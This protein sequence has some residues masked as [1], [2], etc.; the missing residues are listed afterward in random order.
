MPWEE[1]IILSNKR[2]AQIVFTRWIVHNIG[3]GGRFMY[4]FDFQSIDGG[5]RYAV[6]PESYAGSQTA[7]GDSGF[8]EMLWFEYPQPVSFVAQAPDGR[9]TKDEE[10]DV[11]AILSSFCVD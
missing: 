4:Q 9:F 7:V 5:E 10:K 3:G 11:I 8:Q 1:Q 2:G 6:V